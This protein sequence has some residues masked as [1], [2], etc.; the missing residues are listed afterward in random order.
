VNRLGVIAL[1]LTACGGAAT[2]PATVAEGV[3]PDEAVREARSLVEE[4]YGSLR[5]GDAE[6]LLSFLAPDVFVIGPASDQILPAG[7]DALVRLGDWLD[8]AKVKGGKHKL[9]SRDLQVVAAP[10]GRAAWA[11]DQIELDGATYAFAAVLTGEDD[12]WT[13]RAVHVARTWKPKQ[14]GKQERVAG[15]P[16]PA[17]PPPDLALAALAIDALGDLE[18]RLEQMPDPEADDAFDVVVMSTAP[19][20]ATHGV[21][22]I[23]KAWKK[24]LKK[25]K[26]KGLP[27]TELVGEPI[28][29]TTPDGALGWVV[30]NVVTDAV[31]HRMFFLYSQLDGDWRLMAIQD[32]AIT[33]SS[34]K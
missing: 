34:Q 2:K 28:T 4:A 16:L 18:V 19:R 12:L 14:L 11:A 21:K 8:A 31:P 33:Q 25:A 9:K 22:K 10:G 20:G 7:S 24:V 13:F 27:E 1:V 17:E 6:G 3:E 26:K 15:A 30:A 32:A 5:R 23:A 29:A